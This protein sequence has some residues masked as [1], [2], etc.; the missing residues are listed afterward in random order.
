M[1]KFQPIPWTFSD[2]VNALN[3]KQEC[4]VY[5]AVKTGE[6]C[7]LV[8]S[9]VSTDSRSIKV[10]E[11]FLALKGEN[12]DGH[13]FI[14]KLADRGIKGF[15][16]QAEF[17]DNFVNSI[18]QNRSAENNGDDQLSGNHDEKQNQKRVFKEGITLFKVDDTLKALGMLAKFQRIRSKVKL[19]AI[20][21]SN[22]KT[23]TRQMI[24]EIFKTR[25]NTL[26]TTG[27]FNNEIGVPLTLL[28]LSFEHQWAIVEMGMNHK[29]E[30]SELSK[31]AAPDIAVITN[32][33]KAHLEGLGSV[34]EVAEAKAEIFDFVG[35]GGTAIIN[36]DDKR[37]KIIAEKAKKNPGIEKIIL[38]GTSENAVIRAESIKHISRK[39]CFTLAAE[40]PYLAEAPY[41]KVN[42]CMNTPAAFMVT[43]AL[44]AAAAGFAA[45]L[46][47][48]EIKKGLE[49][50]APVSG[51]MTILESSFGFH[52]ID[53]TYNANPNSVKGALETLAELSKEQISFAVLGDML[54]LGEK[55]AELHFKTGRKTA[56]SGV[57][58]LYVY[59]DMAEHIVSGAVE[60][61]LSENRIMKGEKK[62][63]VDSILGRKDQPAWILVKGSRG[64]KMEDVVAGLI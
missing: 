52:I 7:R 1:K 61:G 57:S 32:T 15:I 11:L 43:N 3:L 13:D 8:F 21:G 28:K 27:N 24:T 16:A 55:S 51:R 14:E 4:D 42:I 10:D 62:E 9:G 22:G 5:P 59:G 26:A 29:G 64:M 49:S 30:L 50:F 6:N 23:S 47:G 58:R 12:F 63:I 41:L 40:D 37:W 48:N 45:G 20:T 17:F 19:V 38:T 53:D 31:M 25:F 44:A 35:K 46:S 54:E 36:S 34:L 39:T 2:I 18:E 33:A 56:L 60:A